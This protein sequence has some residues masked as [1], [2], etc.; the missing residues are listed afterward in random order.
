MVD[1]NKDKKIICPKCKCSQVKKRGFRHTQ[2]RG[3]IQRY[4]CKACKNAFIIDDGF[5]RMRNSP[6]KI[7]CALDLFYNGVSTRKVQSHFKAFYP[8]NSSWVSIY[9]WVVK[10]AKIMH[11]FTDKLKL[12]IGSEVQVDEVE[13]QRR[14][15]HF[16]KRGTQTNYFIDSIDTTT[17]F[18]VA[19]NYCKQRASNGIKKIIQNAKEKTGNQIKIITTDGYLGYVEPVKRVFG[20]NLKKG[21]YNVEH[22]VV[23][24]LKGEGFNHPIERMHNSLRQRTKT[25]RGFHGSVE[26]ANAILKGFEIYYN[27]IRIHQGINKC[28]YELA[29]DLKLENPNKW[30]ELIQISKSR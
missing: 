14:I 7:T 30:L 20:Y 17:R 10:Y 19:S 8:H 24:Q 11:K 5:F 16:Q 26:S 4:E 18:M 12:N 29:T 2:N 22:N 13:Y 21:K 1:T 6:Q 25:F 15:S 3:K 9:S 27:F 28:P 23:T